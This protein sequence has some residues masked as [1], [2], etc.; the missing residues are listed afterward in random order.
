MINQICAN[1]LKYNIIIAIRY[2]FRN[3]TFSL[4]NYVYRV[5]ISADVF[6]FTCLLGTG[7]AVLSTG[8]Q[9]FRAARGNPVNSLR[10]E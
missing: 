5:N 7:I 4:I 10:Y 6:I 1:M 9:A 2:L 3:K 8:Y